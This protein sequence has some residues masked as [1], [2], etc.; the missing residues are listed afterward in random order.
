MNPLSVSQIISTPQFWN[1]LASEGAGQSQEVRQ[2]NILR[3]FISSMKSAGLSPFTIAGLLDELSSAGKV[4][5]VSVNDAGQVV[6]SGGGE[7]GL[8]SRAKMWGLSKLAPV[9][10]ETRDITDKARLALGS[11]DPG[12]ITRTA[13][14]TFDDQYPSLAP[15]VKTMFPDPKARAGFL[16]NMR[17]GEYGKALESAGTAIGGNEMVKKWA[18]YAL[19]A[20]AAAGAGR[21][22]GAGWGQSALLG[23]GVGALHGQATEAG[24]YAPLFD[25]LKGK[26]QGITSPP[27]AGAAAPAPGAPVARTDAAPAVPGVAGAT[28]SA[29][30]PEAGGEENL[31]P[32]LGTAQAAQQNMKVTGGHAEKIQRG[33]TPDAW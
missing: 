3:G 26:L 12:V 28:P 13:N 5:T 18:P 1:K 33:V 4:A 22:A 27:V 8:L 2:E 16:V 32:Q 7:L 24:G 25:K 10:S 23:L 20:L 15:V 17:N 29:T 11:N 31:A 21:L 14:N 19:P 6:S 30:L 9:L